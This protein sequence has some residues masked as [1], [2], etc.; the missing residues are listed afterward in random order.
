[1]KRKN[2]LFSACVAFIIIVIVISL[3][4]GIHRRVYRKAISPQINPTQPAVALTF[5]DGPNSC[6]TPQVL[7]ILYEQQVPATFFLMGNKFA[8]NKPLIQEMAASGHELESHTFSHPDLT[9][10]NAEEIQQEIQQTEKALKK[11]LPN[12]TIQYVRPPY[13]RYNEYVAQAI[14][15]PLM[16]W[17]IDSGDW[18]NPDAERIYTTVV[19]CI[20]DGDIIVFHDNNPETVEALERI[21]V[22]L[23][24]KNFQF[25]TVSQLQ[26]Y[27]TEQSNTIG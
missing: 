7:D 26:L 23:K 16:L 2:L 5:D 24:S 6:Y 18:E 13:G 20:K 19:N 25:L 11:I 27:K 17:T 8:E 4:T 10:L 1:M 22:T 21:I 9:T 3:L 15:V 14:D 12:H